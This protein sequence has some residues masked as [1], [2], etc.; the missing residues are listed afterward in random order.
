[1]VSSNVRSALAFYEIGISP[2][3]ICNLVL[4]VTVSKVCI[5]GDSST[6]FLSPDKKELHRNGLQN[7]HLKMDFVY[8]VYGA[9]TVPLLWLFFMFIIYCYHKHQKLN[10]IT[11][12][13]LLTSKQTQ[14]TCEIHLHETFQ[15]VQVWKSSCKTVYRRRTQAHESNSVLQF[16]LLSI[17]EMCFAGLEK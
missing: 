13:L 2:G 1:M 8:T 12:S 17:L 3:L 7:I 5:H 4:S 10:R 15:S 16:V 9:D 6:R 14:W 11:F